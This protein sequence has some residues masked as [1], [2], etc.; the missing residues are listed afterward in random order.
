MLHQLDDDQSRTLQRALA[1]AW[2]DTKSFTSA[3]TGPIDKIISDN[4]QQWQ[5][6][7]LAP[8]VLESDAEPGCEK[9]VQ[10]RAWENAYFATRSKLRQQSVNCIILA[11]LW[12]LWRFLWAWCYVHKTLIHTK[13]KQRKADNMHAQPGTSVAELNK[14]ADTFYLSPSHSLLQ[15]RYTPNVSLLSSHQKTRP[16]ILD[17][18]VFQG[19]QQDLHTGRYKDMIN[20]KT[21]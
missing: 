8:P 16:K 18:S 5:G 9:F 14:E 13:V 4:W 20:N 10:L 19:S 6:G 21:T 3:Q 1:P 17:S 15:L 7:G 2:T 12:N 11:N